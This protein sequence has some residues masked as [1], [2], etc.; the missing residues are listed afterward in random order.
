MT[1][2]NH[3]TLFSRHGMHVVALAAFFLLASSSHAQQDELRNPIGKT[4]KQTEGF[5]MH[6]RM[7]A[8]GVGYK[9]DHEGTGGA[10]GFRLG[11]GLN[12]HWSLFMGLEGSSGVDGG[13]DFDGLPADTNYDFGFVDFGARYHF[14]PEHR[15]VPF[16]EAAFSIMGLAYDGDE[17]VDNEEVIYG[18][19]GAS[20]AG[21]VG[22]FVHPK[23]AIEASTIFTPGSMLVKEI[24]GADSD[25]SLGTAG[26][27]MNIGLSWYPFR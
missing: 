7:G 6:A 13:G 24:G 20:L 22:Y 15:L 9:G 1:I 23:L 8:M 11:Y 16:A 12:E 4:V 2:N 27:R 19:L 21:G 17:S 5:F 3:T 10:G 14:R 26:I 25:I 18:G